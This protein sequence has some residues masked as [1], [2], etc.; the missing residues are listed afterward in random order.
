MK[1]IYKSV[2]MIMPS[3]PVCKSILGGNGSQLLPYYCKCGEWLAKDF[4]DFK[5]EY[6]IVKKLT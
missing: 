5:G 3:C 6:E 4:F 2:K 1:I